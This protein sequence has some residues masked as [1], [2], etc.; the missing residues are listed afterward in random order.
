MAVPL[1]RL[2]GDWQALPRPRPST[3]TGTAR[4]A[5]VNPNR[6][7]IGFTY[8]LGTNITL[9]P[10]TGSDQDFPFILRG[11]DTEWFWWQKHG[12]IVGLAWQA[13][14]L[15]GLGDFVSV[16]EVIQTNTGG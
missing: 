11:P 10:L 14:G 4:V 8:R 12:P 15:T 2:A 1:S 9:T 7:A 5:D 3:N 13:N 16:L 6:L